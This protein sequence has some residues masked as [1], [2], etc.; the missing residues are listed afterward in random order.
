VKHNPENSRTHHMTQPDTQH[1]DLRVWPE[2][3]ENSMVWIYVVGRSI[4]RYQCTV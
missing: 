4:K 1:A 2:T 3:T